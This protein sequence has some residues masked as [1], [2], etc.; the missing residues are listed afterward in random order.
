VKTAIMMIACA[1]LSA[2][3]SLPPTAHGNESAAQQLTD[4]EQM[5]GRILFIQCRACH[6]VIGDEG[7][8]IGPSLIGIFGRPA[9]SNR[10]FAGYSQQL[11]DAQ[12]VWDDQT[13]DRWIESPAALAPGNLMAYAG[14]ASAADRALL[15]RYLRQVTQPASQ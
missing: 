5:R 2:A 1:L 8:K 11:L 13:M 4:R 14:M 3:F 7:E 10:E 9:A 15:V 12:L 6:A